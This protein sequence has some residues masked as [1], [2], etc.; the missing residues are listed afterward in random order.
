MLGMLFCVKIC[1]QNAIEV[2]H[3]ADIV[4]LGARCSRCVAP[5]PSCGPSNSATAP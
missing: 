1:P 2:R 5:T 4:P 3:Y